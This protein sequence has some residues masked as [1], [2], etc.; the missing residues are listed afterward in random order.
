[1]NECMRICIQKEQVIGRIQNDSKVAWGMCCAEEER[2][3]RQKNTRQ[4][5][6]ADYFQC[7]Y[8]PSHLPYRGAQHAQCKRSGKQYGCG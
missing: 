2:V 6:I 1:M 8:I 7:W 4:T 5:G 3:L